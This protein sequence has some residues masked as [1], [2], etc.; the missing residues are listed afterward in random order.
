MLLTAS[1][2][3]LLVVALVGE[4]ARPDLMLLDALGLLLAVGAVEPEADCLR[5]GLPM[6]VVGAAA[7]SLIWF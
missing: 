4:W 1:V 5:G 7:L 6:N 3:V 2:L